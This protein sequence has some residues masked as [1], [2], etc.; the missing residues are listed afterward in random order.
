M[1]HSATNICSVTVSDSPPIRQVLRL[2]HETGLS[3][4]QIARSL[5][6]SR[7]AVTD[8]LI[9]AAAAK[10]HWPLPPA[11]DDAML[12][13][14]LFPIVPTAAPVR[15]PE[16]DWAM[17]HQELKRSKGATLTVLH[18][19]YLAE[20]PGGMAYSLFCQRHREFQQ[21][22][23]RTMRQ[24]YVAGERVFVDY[25]GPTVMIVDRAA[26]EVLYA[27]IF[28]GVLG[29][30]NYIY[31]EAHWSQKLPDWIAAHARMFE[32][33]GGV[34]AVVVCD[35][36]KSAVTRASRTEPVVNTT[37]QALAEHY[38]TIILPARARKPKDKAKAENGVLI[39]ERWILFRLRKRV[40]TSLGEL[41][42]AI[43]ELLIDVNGRPF[44]KLPGSR[45]SVFEA[46]DRPAL[47]S[48]PASHYEYAEFRKLR[49]SMDYRIEVDGCQYSVPFNL[50]RLEVELRITAATV[51][52]LYQGQRVASHA[53][54]AGTVPVVDPQHMEAAHR[55][56]GLWEPCHA[57]EWAQ[58]TGAFVHEFLRALLAT[59]RVREQGYR[60]SNGLRKLAA[61]F[62]ND[63][64]DAACRRAIEIGAHSLASLRS[65]LRNGLD[66]QPIS[67]TEPL[68]AAFEHPNV[69]GSGY[70]H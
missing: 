31:A 11:L 66:Q 62:G 40:F 69:R 38:G 45:Q 20:H 8:Y 29:A 17:V 67:A 13:Q 10:L 50:C 61:D 33:F 59:M 21:T 60:A 56:F 16:P 54:S 26:R 57:L 43:R 42:E 44:K 53:R 48:L 32:H 23:K 34:P 70:Y 5:N 9:R 6:I 47:L 27:Q 35:N 65:I 12:E 25:A 7:D 19:E 55:H 14:K 49:V 3:R 51:E 68:E 24:T 64:L 36:L 2:H 46:I 22:L 41:N 1:S 30:S 37:Y 4:R 18:E 28:V 39:V 52:V 58:Q 15:K 63:R